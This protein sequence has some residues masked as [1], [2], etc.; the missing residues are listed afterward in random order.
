MNRQ[1]A[2][3]QYE[4]FKLWLIRSPLR[5]ELLVGLAII[6]VAIITRGW[7]IGDPAIQMDEQ[8]YLLVG[9]RV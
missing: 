4:R 8:F 9:D 6:T 2:A 5:K 3:P 7:R 1:V